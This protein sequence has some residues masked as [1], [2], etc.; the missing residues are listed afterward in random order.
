MVSFSVK[1]A[2]DEQE[3]GAQDSLGQ[4]LKDNAMQVRLPWN[5]HGWLS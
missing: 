5:V 1:Y 4:L 2:D 3:A